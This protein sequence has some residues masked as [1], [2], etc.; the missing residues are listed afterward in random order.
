MTVRAVNQVLTDLFGGAHSVS[1]PSSKSPA[2]REATAS[3]FMTA[4]EVA[5]SLRI[6]RRTLDDL[7]AA[8]AVPPPIR[9][10]RKTLRW[11]RASVEAIG[12][13]V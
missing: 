11:T 7:V 10:S 12:R 8:G 3:I 4:S 1:K 13:A 5:R 2:A 6:G 9:L